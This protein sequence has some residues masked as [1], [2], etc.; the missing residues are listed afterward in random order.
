[1]SSND[2]L[3]IMNVVVRSFSLGILKEGEWTQWGNKLGKKAG[4]YEMYKH[5]GHPGLS[6]MKLSMLYVRLRNF[7]MTFEFWCLSSLTNMGWVWL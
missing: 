1:M 4:V 3:G 6:F 7:L 5:M 2:D